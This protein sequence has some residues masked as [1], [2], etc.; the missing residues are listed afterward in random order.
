M[1]NKEKH[2]KLFADIIASLEK[3]YLPKS[4]I[5][6]GSFSR[7]EGSWNSDLPM[8]DIDLII[9]DGDITEE[10]VKKCQSTLKFDLN[11]KF[12]DITIY[13]YQK[14]KQLKPSIFSFDLFENGIVLI[15]DY[16]LEHFQ[17][18]KGQITTKDIEILFRTRL[19]TFIGSFDDEKLI[20]LNEKE[21]IFFIYQM[22]KA[23]FACIDCESVLE[24]DYQSKYKD[25]LKWARNKVVFSEFEEMLH[26]CKQVKILNNF[27]LEL[28]LDLVYEKVSE[29]FYK[30]FEKG[31]RVHFNTKKSLGEIVNQEYRDSLKSKITRKL[32]SLKGKDGDKIYNLI[33]A[34]FYIYELYNN[35]RD[36]YEDLT[37]VAKLLGIKSSD[38]SHIR[39]R[40]AQMR[41][42]E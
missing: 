25:K 7:Y 4:V 16:N 13:D 10:I 3:I 14:L 29:L 5:L 9:I 20:L 42:I 30:T 38:V 21:R 2:N 41:L 24:Q 11:L 8:N 6:Y 1:N 23:V 12:V 26:L 19:W 31:L 34:Q 18:D 28:N 22:V 39:K 17:F 37:L 32:Y 36:S 15:G 40:V 35:H 27:D 33:L